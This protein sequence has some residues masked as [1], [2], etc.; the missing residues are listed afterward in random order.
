MR[1]AIRLKLTCF[2]QTFVA[3]SIPGVNDCV[4]FRVPN[5][6]N[7]F[8]GRGISSVLVS[9]QFHYSAHS[10]AFLHQDMKSKRFSH[11]YV[12]V[13]HAGKIP[14]AIKNGCLPISDSL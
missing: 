5:R 3:P 10:I 6:G 12:V 1:R 14:Y 7:H 2:C 9:P 4:S 8:S 11:V 13:K